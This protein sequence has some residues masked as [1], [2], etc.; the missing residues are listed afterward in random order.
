MRKFKTRRPR[1]LRFRLVLVV[2]GAL[3][4]MAALAPKANAQ[5][6]LVYF[7]FEDA[8]LGGPP[9]FTS[10]VVGA[11][12]FNPGGG[13]VLTTI[14]TNAT[15]F[16]AVAGFLLNR[17]AGDIDTA[18]PG[19]AVGFRTTPVDNGSYIQFAFNGT[20]FANMS[21]SFAVN[22]AGNGFNNVQ[23]FYSTDGV[24]F[25]GG[26]S[27]FIPTAGVQIITLV[28][29]SAVDTQAN[30]TL[31]MVF[32]GG[33]SMGNNLQ[34]IIDNIQLVGVPEPTTVAGGLL[35]LLGLCWHQR[36]RIRLLLPRCSSRRLR[37][38]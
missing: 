10:D 26:P 11:P 16:A 30:V 20:F 2:A 17:T 34:T 25:I 14:T 6:V 18:N 15:N 4:L 9:D 33:T 27:S 23:L 8:T 24:N 12:D 3:L 31:R 36:R 13:L 1:A 7:N 21:L 28:V 38:A 19:L 35:G 22:T 32:T 37:C 5:N 29:P